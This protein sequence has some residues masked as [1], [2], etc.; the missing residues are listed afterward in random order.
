MYDSVLKVTHFALDFNND[1]D[2]PFVSGINIPKNITR[3]SIYRDF[4]YG[5]QYITSKDGRVCKSVQP[6]DA[7]FGDCTTRPDGKVALVSPENILLNVSNAK[8]YKYG[9]LVIEGVEV[10]SYYAKGN[11]RDGGHFVVEVNFIPTDWTVEGL[12]GLQ[13]HSIVHYHKVCL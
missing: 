13:L 9:R 6:L 5:I 11:Q 3:A 2:I 12:K 10:E 7:S 8:F 4:N 1:L